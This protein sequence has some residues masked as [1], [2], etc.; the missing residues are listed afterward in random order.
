MGKELDPERCQMEL[1]QTE[2]PYTRRCTNKAT[3]TIQVNGEPR[4][5]CEDCAPP[6]Q[7]WV[8]LDDMLREA[9]G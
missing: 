7:A 1:V 3:T 5:L 8:M 4:R 9:R 6:V 2:W